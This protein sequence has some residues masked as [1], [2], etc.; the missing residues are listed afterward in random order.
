MGKS[1]EGFSEEVTSESSL[2]SGRN[3][4][5]EGQWD[6][7]SGKATELGQPTVLRTMKGPQL[8][9]GACYQGGGVAGEVGGTG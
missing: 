5:G 4:R 1:R 6:A 2:D 3:Q 7:C 8:C 9:S